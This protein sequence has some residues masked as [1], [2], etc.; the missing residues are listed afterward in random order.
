[1]VVKVGCTSRGVGWTW[2]TIEWVEPG[3]EENGGNAGA[4]DDEEEKVAEGRAY[5][6]ASSAN[7]KASTKGSQADESEPS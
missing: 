4:G 6:P 7:G 5:D 2:R 1:M 3:G